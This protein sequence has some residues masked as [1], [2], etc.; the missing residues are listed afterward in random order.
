MVSVNDCVFHVDD[1]KCLH[2]GEYAHEDD[3]VKLHNGEWALQDDCTTLHNGEYAL[4]DDCDVCEHTKEYYLH[5]DLANA[6]DG[7]MV[8]SDNLDEYEE[9]IKTINENENE[10]TIA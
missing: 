5:E 10:T 1:C 8:S 4:P 9:L 2:D 3:C 7:S 6:S